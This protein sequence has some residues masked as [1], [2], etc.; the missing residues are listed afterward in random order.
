MNRTVNASSHAVARRSARSDEDPRSAM[1]AQCNVTQLTFRPA[2]RD[3][4]FG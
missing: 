4:T 2:L 1:C 3:A